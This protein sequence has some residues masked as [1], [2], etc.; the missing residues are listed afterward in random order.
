VPVY[1]IGPNAGMVD[2]IMDNTDMF[3][4]CGGEV[5]EPP[6]EEIYYAIGENTARGTVQND[7][8]YTYE[9]DGFYEVIQEV[10]NNPNKNGYSLLE[11]VWTFNIGSA[12]SAVFYVEAFHSL[13]DDGDDFVFSYS[14]DGVYY[15]NMGTVYKTSDDDMLLYYDFPSSISGTVYVRVTDTDHTKGNKFLDTLS[16]DQMYIDTGGEVP[17]QE[18]HYMY[19]SVVLDTVRADKG[20]VSGM[21]TVTIVDEYGN[22]VEGAVVEGYFTGEV[23]DDVFVGS[24]ALPTDGNGTVVYQTSTS[25]KKP[26]FGFEVT[27]VTG[28]L[29]W[30]E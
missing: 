4:V 21:A 14:T 23:F 18:P 6:V 20:T 7:Y 26:S 2:G 9:S 1:A 16:V 12:A 28:S 27:N 22:P 8:T 25:A 19:D 10:L 29:I 5:T 3:T 11:H 17:P 24:N 15:T 13:S 30:V